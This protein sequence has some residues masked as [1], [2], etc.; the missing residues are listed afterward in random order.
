MQKRIASVVIDTAAAIA[1]GLGIAILLLP[2]VLHLWLGADNDAYIVIAEAASRDPVILLQAGLE[3]MFRVDFLL[4]PALLIATGL[5]LRWLVL[6]WSP[7]KSPYEFT[8][9]QRG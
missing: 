7:A 9:K 2:P 1:L 6:R 8:V 4:W 5:G 3:W